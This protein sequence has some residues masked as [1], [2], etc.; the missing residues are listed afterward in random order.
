MNL[1][2][3]TTT[4]LAAAFNAITGSNIKKFE[5]RQKAEARVAAALTERGLTEM[6]IG[7]VMRGETISTLAAEPDFSQPTDEEAAQAEAEAAWN[8]AAPMAITLSEMA[9]AVEAGTKIDVP[10]PAPLAAKAKRKPK[11]AGNAAPQQR[12][13]KRQII[14]DMVLR[15]EGATEA[16]ICAAIG[17]KACLVTLR[18]VAVAQG[19]DLTARKDEGSR[20]SRYFGTR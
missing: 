14:I 16:E 5:N 13:G 15:T 7:T 3:Y 2:V 8:C 10:A 19:I 6:A 17:W 9:S 18:R 11:T 12:G 20:K 4:D 1:A